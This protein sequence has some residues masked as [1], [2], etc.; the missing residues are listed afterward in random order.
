[1]YFFRPDLFDFIMYRS[2]FIPDCLCDWLF[3]TFCL[4]ESPG[5]T[6][7]IV[8]SYDLHSSLA[9]GA[10]WCH[11]SLDSKGPSP[12]AE[13]DHSPGKTEGHL[14]VHYESPT[15]SFETSLEDDEGQYIPHDTPSS[16]SI[17]LAISSEDEPSSCVLASCSF[18]DHSLHIWLWDRVQDDL[19]PQ[20]SKPQ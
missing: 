9:Y 11:I 13:V 2:W 10:D 12:E 5:T 3:L 14:R 15:A 8:A 20:Q 18:Y 6:C 19:E 7:P 17:N 1:M 16:S 4:P